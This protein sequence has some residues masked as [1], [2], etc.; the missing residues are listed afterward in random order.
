MDHLECPHTLH[1]LLKSLTVSICWCILSNE[2]GPEVWLLYLLIKKLSVQCTL[3]TD[4]LP[5]AVLSRSNEWTGIQL[6]SVI[7]VVNFFEIQENFFK[8]F[9]IGNTDVIAFLQYSGK[10]DYLT[11]S[12]MKPLDGDH[13]TNSKTSMQWPQVIW[14]WCFYAVIHLPMHRQCLPQ[15]ISA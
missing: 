13:S 14:S 7:E 2:L 1:T 12:L 8:I 10:A 5:F 15:L 11:H 4:L 3:Q 6:L 9:D